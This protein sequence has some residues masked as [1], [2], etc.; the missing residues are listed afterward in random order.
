M[1]DLAR[2]AIA[3]VVGAIALGSLGTGSAAAADIPVPQGEV[4]PAPP[5]YYGNSQQYYG[6]P[7]AVGYAPPP[8][9]SY[10]PVLPAYGYY[11]GPPS[12]A[13][14]PRPYYQRFYYGSGYGRPFYGVPRYAPYVARGYGEY[15]RYRYRRW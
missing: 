4:Q 3:A 8:V 15:G 13:V 10:P 9:Y 5:A 6:V 14:L 2:R 12:V 1:G 11:Y 7:P